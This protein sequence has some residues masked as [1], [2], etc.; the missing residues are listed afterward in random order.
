MI[1]TFFDCNC[2]PRSPPA[3]KDT[4]PDKADSGRW[5]L[6]HALR[7]SIWTGE[8]AQLKLTAALRRIMAKPAVLESSR[9]D[10]PVAP[11]A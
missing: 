10:G 7:D 11:T 8:R 3:A 4:R 1:T 9:A 5:P 6:I 2:K